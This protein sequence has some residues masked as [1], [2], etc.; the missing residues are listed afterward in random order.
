MACGKPGLSMA[1]MGHMYIQPRG[2]TFKNTPFKMGH[3]YINMNRGYIFKTR[4]YI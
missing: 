4:A 2:Y 3:M 1:H